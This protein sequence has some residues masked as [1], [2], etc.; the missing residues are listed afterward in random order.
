MNIEKRFLRVGD[1]TFS[2]RLVG[3]GPRQALL[4]HGFPDD[5][6]SLLPLAERLARHGFACAV[7]LMRGYGESDR[8]HD[9]DYRIAALARDAVGLIEALGAREAL[10]VGHDWGAIAGYAA[11]NLDPGRVARLVAVSV[12]PARTFVRNLA[13]S[14][15]Q[16]VRSRYM[17]LFQ[18]P[19]LAER[20]VRAND[21]AYV[22]QLWRRWSP[23][24]T[25]PPERLAQV[26]A[27]LKIQ[28]SL[29]AALA[30]YRGLRLG[31]PLDV[32]EQAES[33]RLALGLL[34]VPTLVVHGDQDGC[35][36]P[37]MYAGL[38][39]AFAAP[40]RLVTLPGVGHWV[41]LE[42]T[43]RLAELVVEHCARWKP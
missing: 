37:E 25:P 7:P 18:V 38:D 42:A 5:A 26:K 35:I 31:S 22:E 13:T 6:G 24:W 27:T 40:R 36:G 1:Q 14:P 9:G 17:A 4:L 32:P 2:V 8:A 19:W 16:V 12:P 11:A 41:P 20:M 21:L 39:D 43:D 29:E 30:Y 15:A 23:G 33:L 34:R 3:T 28:G 10:I